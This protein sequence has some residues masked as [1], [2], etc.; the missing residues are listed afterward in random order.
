MSELVMKVATFLRQVTMLASKEAE[1]L[2]AVVSPSYELLRTEQWCPG[3]LS[4]GVWGPEELE[5]QVV[6][7]KILGC[8]VSVNLGC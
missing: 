2:C 3:N 8:S 4:V 5:R 6:L 7:S 1:S